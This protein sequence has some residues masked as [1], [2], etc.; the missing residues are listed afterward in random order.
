[1]SLEPRVLP[2]KHGIVRGTWR[3]DTATGVDAMNGGT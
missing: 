3:Q 2:R 1:M